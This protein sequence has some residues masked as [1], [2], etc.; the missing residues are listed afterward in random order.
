MRFELFVW[1]GQFKDYDIYYDET[2]K[3][4]TQGQ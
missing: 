2:K 4:K 1:K 3:L